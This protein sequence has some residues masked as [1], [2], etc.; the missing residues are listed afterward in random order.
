MNA[1]GTINKL[2]ICEIAVANDGP[3]T[4]L[5]FVTLF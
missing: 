1:R 5:D 2:N 3:Q 4:Q